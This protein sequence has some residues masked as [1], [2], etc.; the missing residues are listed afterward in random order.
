MDGESMR[1]F[2]L[3]DSEAIL[4]NCRNIQE[5]RG[6]YLAVSVLWQQSCWID[7]GILRLWGCLL[8]LQSESDLLGN[9]AR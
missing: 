6:I 4:R 3:T 9:A 2:L 7:R 5:T 1:G 8:Y